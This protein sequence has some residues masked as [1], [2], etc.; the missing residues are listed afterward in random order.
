MTVYKPR[1]AWTSASRGGAQLTGTKLL[2]IAWHWPGTSQDVIGFETEAQ[3]ANRLRG[4]RNFHVNTRGW[5][6]IGYNFA[7][8]QVGRVWDLRGLGRVGAHAA[9]ASNPDANHE[10]M[11]VL[12]ILGD[13]ERPSTAMIRAC[14][15][16]THDVFLPR[17]P[18]RT[19]DTGHGR[20]PGVP[21][22]QTSCP[23]PFVAELIVD[24]VLTRSPQAPP[25]QEDDD[26]FTDEDRAQ[27]RELYRQLGRP[28]SSVDGSAWTL[29]YALQRIWHRLHGDVHMNTRRLKGDLAAIQKMVTDHIADSAGLD[30]EQ[31]LADVQASVED[32]VAA[33]VAAEIPAVVAAVLD[34]LG[35]AAADLT[36]DAVVE[37]V[38]QALREGV[39]D[40]P[41]A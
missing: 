29:A 17:W 14:Q 10:W 1:S 23:G 8:D 36:Q 15:D 5:S 41:D 32:G 35:D 9:S 37:A 6:D 27:L 3:V 40:A 22:A 39:A 21:G 2:G 11:G 25:P 7:I 4:Y 38:K 20:A 28:I 31:L 18:G 13:R 34:A 33:G 16:F 24:D 19:R 12:L 30:R 26:M